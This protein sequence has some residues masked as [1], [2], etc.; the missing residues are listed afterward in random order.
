MKI[1]SLSGDLLFECDAPTIKETLLIAVKNRANLS[2]ANLYGA[3]LS[4]ADLSKAN[5][6][7]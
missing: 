7:L 2:G 6:I 3:N 1:L 4:G 5:L